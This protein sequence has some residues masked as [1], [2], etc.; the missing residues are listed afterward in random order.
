MVRVQVTFSG[1]VQGVG[2]RW[3]VLQI[4]KA[5]KV[6]GYV[7]NLTNGTVEL[8]AEGTEQDVCMMLENV[9]SKLK[10]FWF[11]KSVD[12]RKGEPHF[13]TFYIEDS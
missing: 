6:T 3:S 11:S 4:A 7:Q 8:L 2:F 12:E 9:E 10:D 1:N 13:D 5:Y